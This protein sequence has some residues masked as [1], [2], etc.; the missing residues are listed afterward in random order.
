MHLFLF[1]HSR[2]VR[3][4]KTLLSVTGGAEV[5]YIV[6]HWHPR[7]HTGTPGH[8]LAPPVTHWHPRSRTGTLGHTLAPP[9]THWHPRSRTGTL[10]HTLASSTLT[11]HNKKRDAVIRRLYNIILIRYYAS[12]FSSL[13][14]SVIFAPTRILYQTITFLISLT[15]TRSRSKFGNTSPK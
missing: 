15:C 11:I 8:T 5:H 12:A 13:T 2:D 3:V 14:K 9:V 7:S 10:G 6:V 1:F 4:W